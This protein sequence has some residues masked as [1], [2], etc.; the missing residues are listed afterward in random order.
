[1]KTGAG[2]HPQ[3]YDVQ[4]RYSGPAGASCNRKTGVIRVF[5]AE[6]RTFTTTRKLGKRLDEIY[7][8]VYR[9]KG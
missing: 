9:R 7:E 6:G 4:G 8:Q 2:G 1:M 5:T 3:A